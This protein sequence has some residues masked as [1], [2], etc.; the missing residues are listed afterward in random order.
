MKPIILLHGIQSAG[1]NLNP[2]AF[3]LR[4]R[5]AEVRLVKL[6]D[7]KWNEWHKDSIMH[8]NVSLVRRSYEPYCH[9]LAFSNGCRIARNCLFDGMHFCNLFFVSAALD[10][11]LIF[12]E[13]N[14]GAIY[15][16]YNRRDRA[17]LAGTLAPWSKWGPMGRTG[18]RGKSMRIYNYPDRTFRPFTLNHGNLLQPENAFGLATII[19][20]KIKHTRTND[21]S[22]R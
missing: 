2:L 15:N 16:F 11:D 10:D 19:L 9:V 17:L 22:A 1:E 13:T 8:Q 21:V 20:D 18:Y 12:P 14:Y 6:V 5:K 3:E 4:Q 7:T